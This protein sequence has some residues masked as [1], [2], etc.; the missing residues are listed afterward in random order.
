MLSVGIM[1][2][3]C[4]PSRVNPTKVSKPLLALKGAGLRFFTFPVF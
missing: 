2:S 3:F 4:E 1:V